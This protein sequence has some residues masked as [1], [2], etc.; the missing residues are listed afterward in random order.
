MVFQFR[1]NLILSLRKGYFDPADFVAIGNRAAA[2]APDIRVFVIDDDTPIAALPAAIWSDAT[3]AVGFRKET[4]FRPK[5]GLL[6]MN[7]PIEKLEQAA[8][9]SRHGIAAPH[10]ALFE[11]G[12]DLPVED[13]GT[14]VL[15]KPAG[16]AHTS[17]NEG[18]QVF[19]RERLAAMT[20]LD[21]PAGHQMREVAMIAQRFIDTG[22][23]PAKY[24]VLTLLGEILYCQFTV[25]IGK[26][27]PLDAP[28]D[29]LEQ[30][31]VGTGG[32]ER[33]YE[34]CNDADVLAFARKV[35]AAF[36]GIPL[37]GIDIIRDMHSGKLF[38]LEVNAWGNVW[39][40]SSD[41]WA[42]RRALYPKVKTDMMNQFG[43]FDVAA[44]ALIAATRRMAR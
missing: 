31:V 36:G 29:M 26:R 44:S 43:A 14:H 4:K 6:L 42:E 33:T 39:H 11:F 5:R 19:H 1:K 17:H 10:A 22:D 3:L 28:D 30:A 41:M 2:K 34:P 37:L 15:L 27:P 38:A 16:F 7:R 18:I 9:M 25:L 32:A 40:F 21:V 20:V 12:M 35:A 13:W 24:R 8:V 23:Y